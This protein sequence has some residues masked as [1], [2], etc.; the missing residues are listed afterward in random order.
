MHLLPALFLLR[1][2]AERWIRLVGSTERVTGSSKSGERYAYIAIIPPPAEFHFNSSDLFCNSGCVGLRIELES[3]GHHL[4]V[5]HVDS[6][7]R[8]ALLSL[9]L[10]FCRTSGSYSG[11]TE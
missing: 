5:T 7:A 9:P 1:C 6:L 3:D 4:R 11:P 8:R 10:S 2:N